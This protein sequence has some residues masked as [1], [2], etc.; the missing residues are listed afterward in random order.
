MLWGESTVEVKKF[1]ESLGLKYK[2]AD[3]SIPDHISVELE[4]M[5][6]VIAKEWQAW[7]KNGGKEALYFLKIEKMFIEDHLIKWIPQFCDKV[8]SEAEQSFYRE[9]AKITKSFI[10]FEKE[11]IDVYISEA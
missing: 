1:V 8:I 6:K 11:N 9:L 7:N 2:E 3:T 5:Q 4:M 10:E